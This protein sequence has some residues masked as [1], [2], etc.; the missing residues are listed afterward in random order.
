MCGHWDITF[1]DHNFTINT[2]R[3]L[4]ENKIHLNKAGV[5]EFYK[6][7]CEFSSKQDWYSA[8]NSVNISTGNGKVLTAYDVSNSL[9]E[10]NVRLEV[11]Q[12]DPFCNFDHKRV[13]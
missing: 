9:S 3:H 2:E 7:V 1:T 6:N 4:S 11:R 12:L 8:D 13:T 10:I 5:T